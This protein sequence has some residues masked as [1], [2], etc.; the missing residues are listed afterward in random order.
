MYP[1]SVFA[2]FSLAIENAA[3]DCPEAEILMGL[4]AFWGPDQVP[5]WLIPHDT[6][7]RRALGDAVEA[8]AAVSL[9][10]HETNH[11]QSVM[12]RKLPKTPFLRDH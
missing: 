7:P 5:L 2:T 12:R 3:Q 9:V 4:L 1:A 6:L 11:K 8:L 10:R